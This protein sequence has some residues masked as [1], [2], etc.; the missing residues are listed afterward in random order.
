MRRKGYEKENRGKTFS[1]NPISK[2]FLFLWL[3]V[4]PCGGSQL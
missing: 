2:V 4:A 3:P 1:T